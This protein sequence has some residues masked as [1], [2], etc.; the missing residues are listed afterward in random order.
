M[1]NSISNIWLIGLVFLFILLF[2]S[3]L[4]VTISYTAAFKIKNEM[5]LIIE[6]H[7][8]FTNKTGENINSVLK[9]GKKVKGN[10]GTFQTIALYLNGS[11]YRAQGTCPT[12][13]YGVN[14]LNYATSSKSAFMEKAQNGKKYYYC[15]TRLKNN[16][17]YNAKARYY[18][19]KI[20]YKMNL[21][22]LGDIFTF[23]IDGTTTE[24]AIP[25]DAST[26]A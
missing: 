6:K 1:K 21:P 23:N 14:A 26:F 4:A 8:G 19:I 22:V 13:W 12:D 24:I 17:S 2:S 11:G 3:Y 18:K 7:D 25:S 5:L 20:F 16:E 9:S 15:F 10:F